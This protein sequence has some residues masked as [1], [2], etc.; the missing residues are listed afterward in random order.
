MVFLYLT[1]NLYQNNFKTLFLFCKLAIFCYRK[2]NDKIL[3]F[4][5]KT[6]LIPFKMSSVYLSS[7][8]EN[9]PLMDTLSCL[10][11]LP[12]KSYGRNQQE[13]YIIA[14]QSIIFIS[15][16]DILRLNLYR[17]FSY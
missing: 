17:Y 15:N 8:A 1:N 7:R 3:I 10:Q 9:V 2:F 16:L 12:L 13:N 5:F 6:L 11:M 4:L 14:S